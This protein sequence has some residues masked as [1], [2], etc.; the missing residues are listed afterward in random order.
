MPK[1][2]V[3]FNPGLD[4]ALRAL[5]EGL[6]PIPIAAGSKKPPKGLEWQRFTKDDRPT[7]EEIC[8]WWTQWPDANVAILTGGRSGVFVIDIDPGYDP[9]EWPPDGIELNAGLIVQTPR[10]KHFYFVHVDG[11]RN[12][13]KKL[14]EG[15]DIR[16]E[17]GYVLI[18]PSV[19]DGKRYEF[20]CGDYRD[21][22]EAPPGLIELIKPIQSDADEARSTVIDREVIP[23]GMRNTTL[24]SL[25]GSMRKKGLGFEGIRST[26]LAVN[27]GMCSP[28]LPDEEVQTVA[29]S[30]C[31][32]PPG[33]MALSITG[34]DCT[35]LANAIRFARLYHDEVRYCPDLK[36]WLEW[37]GCRWKECQIT[38][39]Q[40]RA[41]ETAVSVYEEAAA[42]KEDSREAQDRRDALARWAMTSQS[43]PRLKAMIS[44]ARCQKEIETPREAFDQEPG[45]LTVLNGT[46]DIR[47]GELREHQKEDLITRMAE[48]EWRGLDYPF[49]PWIDFLSDATARNE[50]QERYLCMMTG[51]SAI[52]NPEEEKVFFLLGPGGTG[53]TTFIEAIR[54]ALGDYAKTAEIEAFVQPGKSR[55]SRPRPEIIHLLGARIIFCAEVERG[56]KMAGA[57][58]K[59]LSG[60]DKATFRDLYK[61]DEEYHPTMTIWIA[62][63]DPPRVRDD[64]SG[65][66]RRI[67][68]LSFDNVI[69][70]EEQDKSLKRVLKTNPKARS[71]ILAWIVRGAIEYQKEGYWEPECVQQST[72]EYFHGMNPIKPFIEEMCELSPE[73]FTPAGAPYAAYRNYCNENK[74]WPLGRNDFNSRLKGFNAYPAKSG[75]VRGWFGIKVLR[76]G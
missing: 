50:N 29:K 41:Q 26:L 36:S 13:V 33:A 17:G 22:G 59:H 43:D 1:N 53:K 52:G 49:Q 38:S 45:L 18:P 2:P 60:G 55:G 21:V 7:E 37:D 71:A 65:V 42:V 9:K 47:T 35:D 6:F 58:L 15:V 12:S 28:P 8:E 63:N 3:E 62:G 40:R 39:V 70:E 27:A 5:D 10:G 25:A 34:A 19:V 76:A 64:D 48:V 67:R 14:A 51:Y 74:E 69:P 54:G 32:Y 66:R 16:G 24:F 61:G 30:A 46:L 68:K 23:E 44:Q 4:A 56:Q 73:H 72:E 31:R 20:L 75:G 11:I 57:L